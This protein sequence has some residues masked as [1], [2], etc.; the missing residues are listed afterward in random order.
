MNRDLWEKLSELM[1]TYAEGGCEVSFWRIP[2]GLNAEADR[3]AKA[4]AESGVIVVEYNTPQGIGTYVIR[5]SSW[6]MVHGLAKRL[7]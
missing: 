2:R 5:A 6:W 7:G 4:A 3:A 1:R